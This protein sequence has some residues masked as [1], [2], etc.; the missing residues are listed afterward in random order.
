MENGRI[1]EKKNR[2]EFEHNLPGPT[3]RGRTCGPLG[4][5]VAERVVLRTVCSSP[6]LDLA[7]HRPPPPPMLHYRLCD[8]KLNAG[9]ILLC[10]QS[11]ITASVW[12]YN[13]QY[14]VIRTRIDFDLP[15][16]LIMQISLSQQVK[17]DISRLYSVIPDSR[18]KRN[19]IEYDS[20]WLV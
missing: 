5:S 20:Y 9:S 1:K 2:Q 12:Q 18:Q 6:P 16:L 15:N 11:L 19:D 8:N 17:S 14:C 10:E 3:V 7:A 13:N 4:L